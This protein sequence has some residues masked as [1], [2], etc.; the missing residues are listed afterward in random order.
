MTT[1]QTHGVRP[2]LADKLVPFEQLSPHPKNAKLHDVEAIAD[3]LQAHGQYRPITYQASSGHVLTG[4]GTYEA[5][6]TLGWSH[7]AALPLD[8]DDD[9]ALR[10]VAVD[11]RTQELAGYDDGLLMQLL[12]SFGEDLT[13]TGYDAD[14][15]DDL[16]ARLDAVA[17]MPIQPTDARHA[18]TED[19]EA[20]RAA[21]RAGGTFEARGVVEMLLLFPKDEHEQVRRCLDRLRSVWGSGLTNAQ[22]VAKAV[23]VAAAAEAGD[24]A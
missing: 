13:G 23:S 2:E 3:S 18:E 16:M 4:N 10:I 12:G 6:G 21:A 22:V 15:M 24:E 5:A 17:V 1:Q 7:I 20:A 14:S 8:V 19:D 9:Q 11:N